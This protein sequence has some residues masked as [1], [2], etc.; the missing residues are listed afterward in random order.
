MFINIQDLLEYIT[1]IGMPSALGP[2]LDKIRDGTSGTFSVGVNHQELRLLSSGQILSCIDKLR[3][4]KRI[5]FEEVP[6]L[7][8]FAKSTGCGEGALAISILSAYHKWST[9]S[10][11]RGLV[12]VFR[13]MQSL[14]PSLEESNHGED[15]LVQAFRTGKSKTIR[16]KAAN[17]LAD[18]MLVA[19]T[20]II[21]WNRAQ[22][23]NKEKEE[24][25][26]REEP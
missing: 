14:L 19:E 13:L 17:I 16:K 3:S 21:I 1:G 7:H 18:A 8:K 26:K 24:Q 10:S 4:I 22:Q 6:D 23:K 12:E 9:K 11:E 20:W 5:D 15:E 25:R 2:M